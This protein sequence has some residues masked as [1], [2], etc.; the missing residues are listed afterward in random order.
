MIPAAR[1]DSRIRRTLVN[2]AFHEKGADF[3]FNEA[4][5]GVASRLLRLLKNW[6][7]ILPNHARRTTEKEMSIL[8]T[9]DLG[10]R[11]RLLLLRCGDERFLVGTG[12][13]GVQAITRVG[14]G[15]PEGA[16]AEDVVEKLWP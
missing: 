3:V 9:L 5:P 6:P 1:A 13:A 12:P 8:E 7:R 2:P 15:F 14:D 11:Q 4:R 10:L 16:S